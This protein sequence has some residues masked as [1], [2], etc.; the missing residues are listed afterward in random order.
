[1]RQSVVLVVVMA[2]VFCACSGVST[3]ER[4]NL[5]SLESRQDFIRLHPEGV[6]NK[7][8]ENGEIVPGM[9]VHEVIASWGMP[10]VYV[11]TPMAP[12]EQWIYYLKDSN[13]ESMLI[14]TLSFGNDTLQTWNVDQKRFVGQ[15]VV[16]KEE[17]GPNAPIE[18]IRGTED[19]K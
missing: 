10:N 7:F 18:T 15:G 14:Y 19:K 9:S 16:S 4:A 2:T 1:M 8:I 17:I 12:N 6:H 3:L 5:T 13:S 11:V